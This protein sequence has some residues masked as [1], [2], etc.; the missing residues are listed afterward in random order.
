MTKVKYKQDEMVFLISLPRSGSTLIQSVLAA[1]PSVD[2]EA[3][4]W[5]MLKIAETLPWKTFSSYSEYSSKD[6][7][8]AVKEFFL[9]RK[10][11]RDDVHEFAREYYLNLLGEKRAACFLDKTPRYYL[12][13]D[14]LFEISRAWWGGRIKP[15][16][17]YVDLYKGLKLLD[18]ALQKYRKMINVHIIDYN[19]FLSCPA[20][21]V[22][23]LEA[24][25]EIPEV[26]GITNKIK[27][28][29]LESTMGDKN[30]HNKTVIGKKSDDSLPLFMD[31]YVKKIYMKRY[32]AWVEK[33]IESKEL[34]ISKENERIV[35]LAGI[36]RVRENFVDIVYM[37]GSLVLRMSMGALVIRRLRLRKL[38]KID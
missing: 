18:I 16:H 29:S 6:A 33:S 14:E 5:L 31:S 9:R 12:I 8:I 22:R 17:H 19:D 38:E 35:A 11:S 1:H 13:I 23:A 21:N 4:P 7:E 28:I 36:G 37:I 15:H 32:I 20:E 10:L 34:N 24:F 3:E 27:P 30:I 2:T 26:S 25:L